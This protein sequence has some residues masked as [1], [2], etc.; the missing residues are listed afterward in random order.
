MFLYSSWRNISLSTRIKIAGVFGIPKV[1]PTHVR[2][3]Y[4]ES[5]GYKIEDVERALNVDALQKYLETDETDMATLMVWLVD[6]AEGR[7]EA[8]LVQRIVIDEDAPLEIPVADKKP[9]CDQCDSKG[10]RHKKVCPKN[11]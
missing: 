9:F 11:K 2:D 1:G 10:V 6:K 3:N 5:D 8:R 4:V 7:Y